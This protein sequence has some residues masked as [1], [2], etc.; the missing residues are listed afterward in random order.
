MRVLVESLSEGDVQSEEDESCDDGIILG[1]GIPKPISVLQEEAGIDLDESA[2][3]DLD[4]QVEL[5]AKGVHHARAEDYDQARCQTCSCE[6]GLGPCQ[7]FAFVQDILALYRLGCPCS[8]HCPSGRED[9]KRN[10]G[11]VA[12]RGKLLNVR[13]YPSNFGKKRV[14]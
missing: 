2:F 11:A 4:A 5:N 3:A 10:G 14:A 1:W 6:P 13:V 8:R 9:V 12:I 7:G